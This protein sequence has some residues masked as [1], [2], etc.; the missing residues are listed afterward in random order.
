M[1]TAQNLVCMLF[2]FLKKHRQEQGKKMNTTKLF[3][4]SHDFRFGAL[5]PNVF[6][7][8]NKNKTREKKKIITD[9]F[10]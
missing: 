1:I 9:F 5:K 8:E 10:L 4:H 7:S 3:I 2:F 6:L